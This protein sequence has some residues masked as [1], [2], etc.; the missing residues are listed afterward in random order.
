MKRGDVIITYIPH[1]GSQGGAKRPGL[2]VQ[3]DTNNA[4]LNG[5]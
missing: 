1:I 2:V 5:P 3:S 4:K